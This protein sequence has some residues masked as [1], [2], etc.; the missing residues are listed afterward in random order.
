M[1]VLDMLCPGSKEERGMHEPAKPKHKED[2]LL[3]EISLFERSEQAYRLPYMEFIMH[4]FRCTKYIPLLPSYEPA[5]CRTN[6]CHKDKYRI[7]NS[8]QNNIN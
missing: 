3:E 7:R 4:R 2:G 6:T 8:G 5:K 1:T